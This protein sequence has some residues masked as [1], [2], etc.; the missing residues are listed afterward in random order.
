MNSDNWALILMHFHLSWEIRWI[1]NLIVRHR[2]IMRITTRQR[3]KWF[4]LNIDKHWSPLSRWPFIETR[5][6]FVTA[7]R[8][9]GNWVTAVTCDVMWWWWLVSFGMGCLNFKCSTSADCENDLRLG[10]RSAHNCDVCIK[11]FITGNMS[12]S[13]IMVDVLACVIAWLLPFF[14]FITSGWDKY[15]F[16]SNTLATNYRSSRVEWKNDEQK[17]EKTE[18]KESEREWENDH[19]GISIG[20]PK[21]TE[22]SQRSRWTKSK[23]KNHNNNKQNK[24]KQNETISRTVINQTGEQDSGRCNQ[25][26]RT[27]TN[28]N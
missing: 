1:R 11:L 10:R 16:Q 28:S 7:L 20:P 15:N 12:I 18:T 5:E 4:E 24:T 27:Q 6:S 2:R 21:I 25:T 3:I 19:N 14:Y 17:K 26:V 9:L 13:L 8:H 22:E 23:K